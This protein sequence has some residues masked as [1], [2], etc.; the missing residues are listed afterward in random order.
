MSRLKPDR[1]H[2]LVMQSS[3]SLHTRPSPLKP[4]LHAQVYDAGVLV[5]VA[6][7]GAH[8]CVYSAHSLSS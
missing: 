7:R 1:L 4:A 5:H 8:V 6:V 2:A 3:M